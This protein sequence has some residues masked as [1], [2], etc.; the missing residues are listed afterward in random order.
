MTDAPRA[1]EAD[2]ANLRA[3]RFLYGLAAVKVVF[4]LAVLRAFAAP[5]T[6]DFFDEELIS[7]PTWEWAICSLTPGVLVFL[8]R[9][10][11]DWAGLAY[12]R[13]FLRIPLGFYFIYALAFAVLQGVWIL[14]IAVAA[15]I[16]TFAG[17]R[18]LNGKEAAHAH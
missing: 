7:T 12:E 4:V 1:R 18:Y 15:S 8:A 14:W 2:P 11:E 10:P 13:N 6:K 5:F 16:G 3:P 17:I 9:R